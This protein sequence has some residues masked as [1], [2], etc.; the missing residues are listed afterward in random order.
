MPNLPLTDAQTNALIIARAE[1]FGSVHTP[2]S[3]IGDQVVSAFEQGM[4]AGLELA[5]A[6]PS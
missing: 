2:G 6:V 5:G 3:L 4:W 1:E